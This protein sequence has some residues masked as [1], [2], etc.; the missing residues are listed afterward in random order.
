MPSNGRGVR[1]YAWS[2]AYTGQNQRR[3]HQLRRG[4]RRRHLDRNERLDLFSGLGVIESDLAV[5]S[6][7]S[8]LLAIRPVSHGENRRIDAGQFVQQPR[9]GRPGGNLFA[10]IT[11]AAL[12]VDVRGV[13]VTDRVDPSR[14]ADARARNSHKLLA[15]GTELQIKNASGHRL[16]TAWIGSV[17]RAKICLYGFCVVGLSA[18]A[19]E[20]NACR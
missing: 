5:K 4:N 11:Q 2:N 8:N 3:G 10:D 7:Q 17:A 9:L 12:V 13:V 1:S 19:G 18:R 20:K 15:V 14:P 6:A 16:E